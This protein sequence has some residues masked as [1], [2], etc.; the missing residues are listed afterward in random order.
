M[1]EDITVLVIDDEKHI[2]EVLKYN[3]ELDGFEVFLAS[4]GLE[5]IRLACEN[6]PDIIL[7]DWIM[8][9]MNGLKD[10]DKT[11]H[12]PVFMLTAKWK[13]CEMDKALYAGADGYITK[14]I[15]MRLLGDRIRERMSEYVKPNVN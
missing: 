6:K 5:G 7:L 4:T 2:R 15:D 1:N 13:T 14:P 10:D 11:K 12:I 9:E 8:T 3:L